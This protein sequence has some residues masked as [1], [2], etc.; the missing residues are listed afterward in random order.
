MN[1][2]TLAIVL[3][4]FFYSATADVTSVS[5]FL[6]G[7]NDGPGTTTVAYT[8]DGC[9]ESDDFMILGGRNPYQQRA[10]Y[11]MLGCDD[12]LYLG[13]S[14]GIGIG[15]IIIFGAIFA[16]CFCVCRAKFKKETS[17]MGMGSGFSL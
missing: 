4:T 8:G 3:T 9:D 15:V 7:G 16:T 2:S 17:R 5:P 1:F 10:F 6:R 11:R 14:A 13:V 12:A